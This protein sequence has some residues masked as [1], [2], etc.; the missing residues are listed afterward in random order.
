MRISTNQFN[1]V[2]TH[3]NNIKSVRSLHCIV[4]PQVAVMGD[5]L[6]IW[7]EAASKLNKQSHI[8]DMGWS[9]VLGVRRT[10]NSAHLKLEWIIC[11]D[12][13]N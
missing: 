5:G 4:R 9:F 7:R 13:S 6:K 1:T 2:V 11:H 3:L 10:N 12:V 8:G